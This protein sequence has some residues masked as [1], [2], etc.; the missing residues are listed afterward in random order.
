M[1]MNSRFKIYL[2]K[3]KNLE[4]GYICFLLGVFLIGSAFPFGIVFFLISLLI[5][6]FKYKPHF[7]RDKWNYPFIFISIILII[8]ALTNFFNPYF[9][10]NTKYDHSLILVDLLN[11]IPFFIC[12][13]GFQTYVKT[14]PQKLT[15]IKMII[16]GSIPIVISCIM[17]SWF[18]IFGP[19]ELFNGLIIW[20]QRSPQEYGGL[21]GLFSNQNYLGSWIIIIWPFLYYLLKNAKGELEKSFLFLLIILNT[22]FLV[23]TNSRNALI[24]L[25]PSLFIV[26]G[27]KI[28]L[29]IF[30]LIFG[31]LIATSNGFLINTPILKNILPINL[32]L[33]II[34]DNKLFVNYFQIFPR[35]EAWNLGL[36][37]I[38]ERPW[39]GWGAGSFYLLFKERGGTWNAQHLHNLPLDIAYKY[40][41]IVSITLSI[42]IFLII[43]NALRK[44]LRDNK[45]FLTVNK[46]WYASTLS[47]LMFQQ[48]DTTYYDGKISI[49]IWIL[50]AGCKTIFDKKNKSI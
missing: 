10:G 29:I 12:F 3:L 6:I 20:F 22:F 44:I 2:D 23:Q 34:N 49:L 9:T 50:I 26:L 37:F 30:L 1:M 45:N 11:W 15:F 40:G 28:T 25:F 46:C 16:A 48:N 42:T 17:Q 32:F 21:S 39:I 38:N 13:L 4:K 35:V 7:F 5:S 33:K 36:G 41:I 24:S 8:S 27:F 31:L 14:E 19:F 47:I 18:N 43:F